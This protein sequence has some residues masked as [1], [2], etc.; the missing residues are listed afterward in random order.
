MF[1]VP[2]EEPPGGTFPGR[3]ATHGPIL[4]FSSFL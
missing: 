2:E 3:L 4:S 1:W